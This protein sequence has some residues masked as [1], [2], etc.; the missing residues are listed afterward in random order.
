MT[1][2][3]CTIYF[4][5]AISHQHWL[6]CAQF[7]ASLNITRDNKPHNGKRE[8]E[9]NDEAIWYL[10]QLKAFVHLCAVA[11]VGSCSH[12][13]LKF[14][15]LTNEWINEW[16]KK[17][18]VRRTH[19]L[20]TSLLCPEHTLLVIFPIL[21]FRNNGTVRCS[22][23]AIEFN[24]LFRADTE[25]F[26]MQ[27]HHPFRS[28]CT[29]WRQ[30]EYCSCTRTAVQS[31]GY[32]INACHVAYVWCERIELDWKSSELGQIKLSHIN[33]LSQIFAL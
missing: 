7:S 14:V 21:D 2:I 11:C 12:L 15:Q 32:S 31:I 18:Y 22:S 6:K 29:S 30:S 16:M 9:K 26:V 19:T 3:T 27:S 13:L 33:E 24:A 5:Q 8:E 1:I 4:L 25:S 10:E 20:I 28:T 17:A 23:L